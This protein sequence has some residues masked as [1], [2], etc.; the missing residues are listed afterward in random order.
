VMSRS[1]IDRA[2]RLTSANLPRRAIA[3][4]SAAMWRST[5]PISP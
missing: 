2:E 4:P 3:T 5:N 1:L